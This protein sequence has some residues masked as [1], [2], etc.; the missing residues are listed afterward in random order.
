MS[1]KRNFSCEENFFPLISA[2]LKGISQVM[3][4]EN[5][6]TGLLILIAITIYSYYLGIIALLSAM[7]GTLVG[8]AGGANEE[9]I[10]Q[11]LFGYNSVLTGMALAL[12]L[13]GPYIWIV[14][15]VASAIAAVLSAAMMHF[16]KRTQIPVLTAPFIILTWFI[17]LSSYK[18]KGIKLNL[19]LAP[20]NLEYWRLNISGEIN[21][22]DAIIHGIGQVFFLDNLISGILLFIAVLFASRKLALYTAMGNISAVIIAYL[23]GGEHT[24]IMAG[25]Y[26]YN[27]IL[28][29][30]AVSAVFN[31][32]HNRYS[33]FLGIFAAALTVPLVAGIS[34]LLL[35]YGLPVLTMPFVLCTWLILS[36]RKAL[37]NL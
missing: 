17:L 30:I 9:C 12:F 16:L 3:L 15:L 36:T 14:A 35:P 34:S 26:G 8:K 11:G 28:T 19:Q 1:K 29:S 7:I 13:N 2:S 4:I 18:L 10:N 32:N 6:F 23:L 5:T 24:L 25:L 22:I 37:P 20:Q 31:N 27:A 21:L 33:L